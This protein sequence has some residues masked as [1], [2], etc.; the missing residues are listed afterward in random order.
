MNKFFKALK[1]GNKQELRFTNW[2]VRNCKNIKDIWFRLDGWFDLSLIRNNIWETYEIKAD[3]F[4]HDEVNYKNI[5]IPADSYNTLFIEFQSWGKD[6][7]IKTTLADN[8]VI[9]MTRMSEIWII[10]TKE[11]R[12]LIDEHNFEIKEGGDENMSKGYLIPRNKFKH[13]FQIYKDDEPDFRVRDEFNFQQK[14]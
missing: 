10:P 11:L 2:L 12:E 1:K 14:S 13:K 4:S 7:G 8:W 9:I 3:F 5:T 6:S